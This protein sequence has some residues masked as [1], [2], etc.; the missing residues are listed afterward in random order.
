M[1]R[2]NAYDAKKIGKERQKKIGTCNIK[3][4]MITWDEIT[5]TTAFNNVRDQRL[6]DVQTDFE[7]PS[8]D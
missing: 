3:L 4:A 8:T 1:N 6:G 2:K 5:D 7:N